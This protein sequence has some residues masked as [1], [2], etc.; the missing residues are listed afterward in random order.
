M[1]IT[2]TGF[3]RL[4]TTGAT[5]T[6]TVP[7]GD[8][9]AKS[10]VLSCSIVVSMTMSNVPRGLSMDMAEWNRSGQNRL[11]FAAQRADGKNIF[12]YVEA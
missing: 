10:P 8:R 4:T 9:D 2:S 6:N 11:S 7:G 12:K 3:S 5:I 1:V